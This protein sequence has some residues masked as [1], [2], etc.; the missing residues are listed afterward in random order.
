MELRHIRYF[1]AI[2][3]ERHFTRAAAKIGIGQPPLSQQIKDLEAEIGVQLFHRVAHGA[4]LTTAGTAFLEGVKEMPIL[5]EQAANA[6]R[7]ASRGETGSIRVGFTPSSGFNAIVPTA[8]RA[9][10]RAYTDVSLKL[11]ETNTRRLVTALQ[12]ETLD[13][14]FLRPSAVGMETLQLHLLSEQTMVIA[15]PASH[16][17]TVQKEVELSTLSKD[18]FL[19]VPRAIDPTIYDNII[20][21]CRRARFEPVIGEIAPQLGSIV[22]LVAAELG[23]SIV[24]AWMS[25]LQ[26]EGIAYRPIAGDAPVDALA[27]AHRRGDT[28]P[29]VRNFVARALA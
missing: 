21:A 1:L 16:P 6:A 14:A 28:S 3:E 29:I 11:E 9:F 2:A 13:A 25:R 17:A 15:L 18:T 23:V 4:E 26:V 19:I 5:A 7:R 12:D 22:V 20:G 27:L 8:I 24:P 10:R